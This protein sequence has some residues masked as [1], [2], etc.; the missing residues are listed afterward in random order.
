MYSESIYSA[1]FF[2]ASLLLLVLIYQ[3]FFY[4]TS[5]AFT[6]NGR[7][8]LQ[9]NDKIYD[10]FYVEIYDRLMLSNERAK[11]EVYQILEMTKPSKNNSVILDIGCGTGE[12]VAKFSEKGYEVYGCDKCQEMIKKSKEK[13]PY[14][15]IEQGNA[16]NTMLYDRNM[17]SHIL[18]TYYTIYEI[19]DK[20]QLFKNCYYWMM[21]G[22]YLILHLVDKHEFN[23]IIPAGRPYA[24]DNISDLQKFSDKRLKQTNIDFGDFTYESKFDIIESIVI[25]KEEFQDKMTGNIR[26]NEQTLYME[27][28]ED[29][30]RIAI[31]FGFLIVG[32]AIMQSSGGDQHQYL[33]ILERTL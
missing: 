1:L 33:Y 13:Y 2:L 8:V 5:E 18:C 32:K 17:F 16:L 31:Q 10:D 21:P 23:P 26:Q 30:L 24:I 3:Q 12:F 4:R 20:K 25:H 28:T 11:N 19:Q 15:K 7:F 9:Y 22:G 6:Q 27:N 14:A 29:I